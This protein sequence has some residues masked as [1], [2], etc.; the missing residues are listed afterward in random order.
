MRYCVFVM[1][2]AKFS[3]YY[4]QV[5]YTMLYDLRDVVPRL[6]DASFGPNVSPEGKSRGFDDGFTMDFKGVAARDTYLDHPEH[7]KAGAQLVSLL[8]GGWEGLMVFDLDV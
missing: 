3:K 5:V 6:V 4:K 8:E 1:F 7:K 2:R